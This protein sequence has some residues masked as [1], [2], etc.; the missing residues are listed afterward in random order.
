MAPFPSIKARR[1]LAILEAEPLGY[2]IAGH[3]GSHRRL[4]A[5]GR[6]SITFAFHDRDEVAPGVVRNILVRQVGLDEQAA[7]DL[8]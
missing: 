2:R 4:K 1:L 3:S 7:L 5:P 8:L 6:P